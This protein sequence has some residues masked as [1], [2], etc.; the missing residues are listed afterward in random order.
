MSVRVEIDT[1]HE[2]VLP[3]FIDSALAW[4]KGQL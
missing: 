3:G 1:G 2:R 4:A